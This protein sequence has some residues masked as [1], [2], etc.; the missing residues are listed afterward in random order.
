MKRKLLDAC[1]P[2]RRGWNARGAGTR[3][4]SSRV[5]L[6]VAPVTLWLA[7]AVHAHTP[8]DIVN[9][10]APSPQF[11][12][13]RTLFALVDHVLKKSTD[14]GSSWKEIVNG[15]D[16]RAPLSDIVVS[17]LFAADGTLF[18]TSSGD[19]LFRS[20]DRGTSWS[21]S[22]L[23]GKDTTALLAYSPKGDD[24]V[25]VA[26]GADGNLYVSTDKGNSWSKSPAPNAAVTALATVR[27][28]DATVVVA[29]DEKGTILLGEDT[30]DDW[31]EVGKLPG[32]TAI[33]AITQVG[34]GSVL[35]GTSAGTLFRFD[36][37]SRAVHKLESLPKPDDDW[38]EL[39]STIMD[40]LVSQVD[41]ARER[42]I[43]S[44][45]SKGLFTSVDH[46][47]T[48]A[49]ANSGLSRDQ[50]AD[51]DQYFSP[52]FEKFGR[53][54]DLAAN[55]PLY[56]AGF[57]GLFTSAD[58]GTTWSQIET[59]SPAIVKG[60]GVGREGADVYTIGVGSYGGG[61]YLSRDMGNT[62][63][64]INQGLSSSRLA[65]FAFAP[66]ANSKQ[67]MLTGASGALMAATTEDMVWQKYGVFANPSLFTKAIGM[68]QS[69]GLKRVARRLARGEKTA[70]PTVVK[71]SPAFETDATMFLGTRRDGVYRSTDAGVTFDKT[72]TLRSSPITSVEISP[73][74]PSDGQVFVGVRSEG[75]FRTDD[76]GENWRPLG[77]DTLRFVGGV[78]NYVWVAASPNYATDQTLAVGTVNGLH[79]SRDGGD[80]WVSSGLD[81][82]AQIEALAFSPAYDQDRRLIASVKGRG[83]YE[84]TDGGATFRALA[85]GLIERNHV[86]D[87]IRFMPGYPAP[88]TLVGS[89]MEEVFLSEDDGRSWRRLPR[90]SRFEDVRNA[91]RFTGEWTNVVSK[92]ASTGSVKQSSHA[93]DAAELAFSG[94]SVRIIGKKG[95]QQSCANV[96]LDGQLKQT[97]NLYATQELWGVSVFEMQ[98]LGSGGH[99]IRF[100]VAKKCDGEAS[101][102]RASIDAIDVDLELI[103]PG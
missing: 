13:D 47:S 11:S 51:G 19:G 103:Q 60:L 2:Q 56:L 98:D 22:G 49:A 78:R 91:I 30:P 75:V 32:T 53:P 89:S 95:P 24:V 4:P 18:L 35:L 25:T 5:S 52:H 68:A 59:Q 28:N 58:F 1:R 65:D 101:S 54:A 7:F 38:P 27:Y 16:E 26:A 102:Q 88:R 31:G 61:A 45:W 80:T 71:L 94:D 62:W 8:H 81:A 40:I 100:E 93:G 66:N 63:R 9:A 20:T 29:G 42:I 99:V 76:R 79:I 74:Y 3:S 82:T 73:D 64:I 36:L 77:A 48:W 23:A 90:P 69:L 12:R 37:Q 41:A 14:G 6:L 55:G 83:L 10:V 34:D 84:S 57:D 97:P 50:Q 87:K 96:Y 15:L 92:H 70:Y 72:G 67:R 21:R 44:T 43:V 17:P 39:D 85:T 86:L 33:T 46:G